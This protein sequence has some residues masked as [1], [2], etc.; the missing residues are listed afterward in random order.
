MTFKIIDNFLLKNFYQT[1]SEDLK[2]SKIPWYNKE[3]D[4]KNSKEKNNG[5]FFF[6]YYNNFQPD[7]HLFHKHMTPFIKKLNVAA[8]LQVRANLVLRDQ[9]T[10]ESDFHTDY[11]CMYSTTGIFYLT[12][13]NA[14]TIL[15]I[16]NKN[17]SVNSKENRML[18]FDSRISHKVIYQT[19]V[20]KRYVINFNFIGNNNGTYS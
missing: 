10:I 19:D 17:V 15:K 3:T 7:H 8:L 12:N 11:D 9:D 4:V 20:H 1:L 6:C 14:K 18:L 13:C 5:F 16:K 2:S